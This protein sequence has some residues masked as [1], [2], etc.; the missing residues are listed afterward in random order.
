MREPTSSSDAPRVERNA[1]ENG[2]KKGTRVTFMP[3]SETFKITEALRAA[4]ARP[5][6]ASNPDYADFAQRPALVL[7]RVDAK[8]PGGV[9]GIDYLGR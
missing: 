8:H 1:D 3:S 6:M 9:F 7:A 5:G 2:F 4:R